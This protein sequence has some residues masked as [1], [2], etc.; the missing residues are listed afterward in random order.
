MI[1][2]INKIYEESYGKSKDYSLLNEISGLQ[3]KNIFWYPS[4]W[5]DMQYIRKYNNHFLKENNL[6]EIGLFLYSDYRY[7]KEFIS[8]LGI[9]HSDKEFNFKITQLE[10]YY[11]LS[12]KE[13]DEYNKKFLNDYNYPENYVLGIEPD[14]WLTKTFTGGIDKS[15][16]IIFTQMENNYLLYNVIKPF[17]LP[18]KYVCTHCDG[19]DE[20]GNRTS[21]L[22]RPYSINFQKYIKEYNVNWI[23]GE[24][25]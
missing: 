19:K 18:V 22:E 10:G 17:N 2:I 12:A 15:V 25:F 1:K 16:Y 13:R 4:G 7:Y 6:P 24:R 9:P 14:I 11:F 5:K 23:E 8:N 21:F 20:G 3:C